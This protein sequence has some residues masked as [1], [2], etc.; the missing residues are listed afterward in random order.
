M[1]KK[2]EL[3]TDMQMNVNVG[4]FGSIV[5]GHKTQLVK[6]N[7]VLAIGN[8]YRISQGIKPI[9]SLQSYFRKPST[10]R[11]IIAIH[12]KLIRVENEKNRI[13]GNSHISKS[14][15]LSYD[16]D[17]K[18]ADSAMHYLRNDEKIVSSSRHYLDL[19]ATMENLPRVQT[20]TRDWI[21]YVAIAKSKQFNHILKVQHGGKLENRGYYVNLELMMDIAMMMNEAFKV[22][23]IHAF[24]DSHIIEKRELG[25]V[26]FKELNDE[27]ANLKD[28]QKQNKKSR[29]YGYNFSEPAKLIKHSLFTEL[30]ID[31]CDGVQ[32]WNTDYATSEHH[33]KRTQI[34]SNL[35]MMMKIGAISNHKQL[36]KTLTKLLKIKG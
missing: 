12:N 33:E 27:I 30:E 5:I 22:D 7:D 14:N 13:V 9:T 25:G 23:I 2:H 26:Y 34:I 16:F 17:D 15:T 20:T 1:V 31:L 21:D 8:S 19:Q 10:W 6:V 3:K 35:V 36:M 29:N 28:V 11:T 32:I 4:S 18:I 24:I